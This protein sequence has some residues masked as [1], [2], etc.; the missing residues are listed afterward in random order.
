MPSLSVTTLG[1]SSP[2]RSGMARVLH[3]D[4]CGCLG[5]L[6]RSHSRLSCRFSFNPVP[7]ALAVLPCAL[8]VLPCASCA[9]SL[10]RGGWLAGW[11]LAV[12][13]WLADDWVVGLVDTDTGPVG[14]LCL[15]GYRMAYRAHGACCVQ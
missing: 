9:R 8:A 4:E 11:R 5:H 13:G 2:T 3:V 14:Q 10:Q 12:A 1:N 6:R 7:C 15:L